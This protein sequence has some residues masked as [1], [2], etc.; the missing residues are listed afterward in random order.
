VSRLTDE[1][2]RLIDQATEEERRLML[3]Y[4]RERIPLHTLETEW[5]TTAEEILTAIARSSDLTLRG[6]RGILAEA[7]FEKRVLPDLESEGWQAAK[8]IG[9]QSFDFLIEQG[10]SQVRI[11]VKLQRKERGEPKE[12]AARSR[13]ALK[14]PTGKIYVVEVQKTRGGERDG[15]KTRP[16]RFGDFDIIAVNMHP[17]TGDWQRFVFTVGSW[18]LPRSSDPKLIEIFQPV[19]SIRDEYWTDHLQEC[20]EWLFVG[21]KRRLYSS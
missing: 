7:I 6:V 5:N 4:L 13:A 17:S 8:I 1:V 16:Y 12:Y 3:A 18:L 21:K 15:E 10:K 14:C 20:I 19:P 11:Q 2:F 9:D